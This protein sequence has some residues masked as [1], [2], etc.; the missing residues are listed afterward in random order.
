MDFYRQWFCIFQTTEEKSFTS[1]FGNITGTITFAGK[2]RWWSVGVIFYKNHN[3]ES[4]IN[5]SCSFLPNRIFIHVVSCTD[6]SCGNDVIKLQCIS[7]IYLVALFTFGDQHIFSFNN[8]Y[9]LPYTG[10]VL[11]YVSI[12]CLCRQQN[13]LPSNLI[14][15]SAFYKFFFFM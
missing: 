5:T 9:R 12:M 3:Q 14:I 7:P 6:Y 4:E 8:G 13:F 15:L 2:I 1:A 11:R 10:F